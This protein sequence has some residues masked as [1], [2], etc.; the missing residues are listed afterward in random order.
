MSTQEKKLF[1][2]WFDAEAAHRLGSQ[3]QGSWADFPLAKFKKRATRQ[4]DS[5]EFHGRVHQFASAL[6]ECLP[7]NT[8]EALDILCRSFPPVNP[9][10]EAINDGWLYWPVGHFI[11]E[12]GQDDF[13]ASMRAMIELTQRF[14]SEFAVRPFVEHQPAATFA[15]LLK[16]TS[17]PSPHVRRWCS[18]G[19]RPRLPWGKQLQDLVRDPSPIWPILEE[20]KDDPSLYVR[21]SVANCLNDIAKDHPEMVLDRCTVWQKDAGKH[22][23]W[24][25]RHAL[26][27]L[28]KNGNPRA[29]SLMG[30]EPDPPVKAVPTLDRKTCK[31]GEQV[32]LR[33][34]LTNTG[35]SPQALLL[36]MM[37]SFPGKNGAL[38]E[39]VFK[40]TTLELQPG[41]QR[42][43]RKVLPFFRRT[44][45]RV[46]YPGKHIIHLQLNG[47]RQGTASLRLQE[48]D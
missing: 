38:R 44:S 33:A 1:K 40:W 47:S 11:A 42:T 34:E 13:E 7:G 39:K 10:S 25:I 4:L 19:V 18:E 9:D 24:I 5:L 30:Y 43:L 8:A 23:Q 12:N 15:A 26:R 28:I 14:S 6:A 41:E 45:T 27:T 46:L 48:F 16:R 31:I 3:I 2:D 21:K 32:E 22:R 29:L 17:H 36:D 37:V 35:T 20:L